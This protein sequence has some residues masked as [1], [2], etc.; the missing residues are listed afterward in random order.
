MNIKKIFGVVATNILIATLFFGC[1]VETSEKQTLN[2]SVE[3]EEEGLKVAIE[4]NKGYNL[5][6]I[7]IDTKGEKINGEERIIA[8]FKIYDSKGE[9]NYLTDEEEIHSK[10]SIKTRG[11]T[12]RLVPKKQ[13]S[14]DLVNSEGKKIKKE[15]L[16]M[17]KDSEWILNAPFEDKSLMRNHLAYSISREIMEYA[18]RSEYCEVFLVDDGSKEIKE[19]HYKGVFL[20]VEKIKRGENR[21]NIGKSNSSKNET[22]FIVQKNNEKAEDIIFDNYGFE[23]Y[24]YDYPVLTSYPK[25]GLT[26]NQRVYI[27][28]TISIFERILYSDKYDDDTMGYENYIEVDSFVDY[29]IINEFFNNTDA[30]ILSTYIYK[31]FGE[32]IKAGPVWDFN[33]SMGNNNLLSPYFDYKGFYMN[34]TSWFDRLMEDKS[35]VAKVISRYEVL[36]KTYLSDE[37]LIDFIDR[38]VEELG[39]AVNRNF[40]VW[41]FYMCNQV[42][43]F[44]EGKNDFTSFGD[45]PRLLDEYLKNNTHLLKST[46]NMSNSFDEEINMLKVFLVN[47]GEW[48][49]ENIRKLYKWTD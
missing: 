36:R 21:V 2:E 18:P 26:D 15:V 3:K 45:N 10:I 42:E 4:D 14:I 19:E 37:Y 13:Y 8:D 12:T 34:R 38:T 43:M 17:P 41:P 20:M 24:I 31:D 6:L 11:N 28:R 35:F 32:K 33:T 39:E 49:D 40:E 9:L 48:V 23:T 47:R 44:K 46:E 22:S 5:P 1:N 27:S 25:K 7:V 29:F 30:S 16:G